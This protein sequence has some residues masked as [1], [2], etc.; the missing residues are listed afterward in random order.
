MSELFN[1]TWKID[2]ERSKVWDDESGTYIE[3]RVG[4][5]II[6]IKVDGDVQDYQVLYG[7]APVI[8]MGYTARYDDPKWVPY[9][10]R[11]IIG[12]DDPES[13]DAFKN[14]INV[15]EDPQRSRD[16]SV[17][18]N[19]GLIRLLYVDERTHYR[20]MTDADGRPQAMMLRRLS[21]DGQSYLA[22]V[23]DAEGTLFRI[24]WFV[25]A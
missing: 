10:V 13:I 7:D 2:L 16:F 22:S 6:T 1:G 17:G 23:L 4:E 14:R 15:N 20:A 5:E 12:S 19:Y 18:H 25:R 11:E 8:R 24:R 9:S 21:A 3:D